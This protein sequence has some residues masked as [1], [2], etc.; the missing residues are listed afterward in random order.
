MSSGNFHESFLVTGF[1]VRM[2]DEGKFAVGTLNGCLR[3]AHLHLQDF[4]WI[5][6]GVLIVVLSSFVCH[7]EK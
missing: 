2:V 3:C 7:I 6:I 1:L 5:E 4:I